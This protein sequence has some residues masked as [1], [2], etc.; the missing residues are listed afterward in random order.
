MQYR[1]QKHEVESFEIWFHNPVIGTSEKD[2]Q[3]FKYLYP[4]KR[5]M[6]LPQAK[7]S[8]Q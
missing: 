4:V 6:R 7:S 8:S 3:G 1:N 5:S 2:E